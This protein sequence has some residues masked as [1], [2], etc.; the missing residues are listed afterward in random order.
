MCLGCLSSSSFFWVI[1][2]HLDL[3][4]EMTA[5]QVYRGNGRIW[6][7][8]SL[9][10]KKNLPSET[11]LVVLRR[12]AIQ[13]WVP[14]LPIIRCVGDK[15]VSIVLV[16]PDSCGV[17]LMFC[18]SQCTYKQSLAGDI[19]IFSRACSFMTTNQ[20]INCLNANCNYLIVLLGT[21]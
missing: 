11:E 2:V 21:C 6:F 1:L 5:K 3:M 17:L 19:S 20:N 13:Y 14:N 12:K 10:S 16:Y 7:R 8:L 9:I 18:W 15:L 4:D